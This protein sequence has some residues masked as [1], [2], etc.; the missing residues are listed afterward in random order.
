MNNRIDFSRLR[1]VVYMTMSN[2][3]SS[4]KLQEQVL[5]TIN[6]LVRRIEKE[7]PESGSFRPLQEDFTDPNLGLPIGKVSF[8]IAPT[9]SEK[10]ECSSATR[11]FKVSIFTPSGVSKASKI[12]L[13]GTKNEIVDSLKKADTMKRIQGFIEDALGLFIRDNLT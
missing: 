3:N 2:A 13:D 1:P 8:Q 6:K 5:A 12:L 10:V 11:F 4:D 9:A 7:V